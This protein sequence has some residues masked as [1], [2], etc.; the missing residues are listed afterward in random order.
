MT[1]KVLLPQKVLLSR[2]VRKVVAEGASGSFGLLPRHV[3]FVEPLVPGI[4]SFVEAGD[5]A[6]EG[7]AREGRSAGA[8][9]IFMAVDEGVLV[10]CGSE[11]LVSVRN[12][13]IGPELGTLEA[14]VR[15]RFQQVDAFE[16]AM[17]TALAKLEAEVMRRFIDL[18]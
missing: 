12:A 4:L 8:G 14:T 18:E 6:A 3:D 10:K 5:Q 13:V 15:D 7:G 1:L 11:V 9:E 16:G 2:A 17:R